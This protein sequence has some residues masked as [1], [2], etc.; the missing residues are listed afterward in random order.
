[1]I[2]CSWR[3]STPIPK[4]LTFY[5]N[6]KHYIIPFKYLILRAISSNGVSCLIDCIDIPCAFAFCQSAPHSA[7]SLSL[8]SVSWYLCNQRCQSLIVPSIRFLRLNLQARIVFVVG[9]SYGD[10][11]NNSLLLEGSAIFWDFLILFCLWLFIYFLFF[12]LGIFFLFS[13]NGR[14]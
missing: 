13:F 7:K 9:I 4:V 10:A 14:I 11:L 12:W 8:L 5:T 1:M 2:F 6:S 3:T